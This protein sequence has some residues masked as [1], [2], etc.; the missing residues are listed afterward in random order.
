VTRVW[1]DVFLIALAFAFMAAVSGFG[2]SLAQAQPAAPAKRPTV[3]S[4]SLIHVSYSNAAW[5]KDPLK[6]E[7]ASILMREGTSGKIVQI[8][9]VETAPNSGV[10]SG[11]YSINWQ[12]L[13][14]LNVEF[15]VPPQEFFGENGGLKKLTSMIANKEIKRSPFVLKKGAGGGQTIQIY[16]SKEQA[17]LAVKAFRDSQLHGLMNKKFPSDQAVDVANMAADAKERAAA[18]K[19]AAERKRLGQTESQRIEELIKAFNALPAAEQAR[20][21]Q[22]AQEASERALA[23]YQKDQYP[24]ALVEFDKALDL[25]P[26]NR[27]YYFPFGVALYKT[28]KFNRSIVLLQLATDPSTRAV[29]RDFYIALNFFRQ[30]DTANALTNFDKVIAT[31]DPA[32]APASVFYEGMIKF[33]QKNWDEA[34][35][36]F[37]KVL[38]SS[39]DQTLDKKAEAYIEQ[40]LRVRQ[41]EAER[42]KKWQ[43]SATIGE[44]Y[45]S[46]V[47]LTSQ[48]AL[49][50]GVASNI[51]GFR[52]LFSGSVRYRP[53][54]EETKEF[55][56]QLD[57]M[58][59]Y[60]TD[61]SLN[62]SQTLRNADPAITT[63]TAPW[64]YK[65]ILF[66]KG[67]KFDVTPG[68]ETIF[69]SVEDNSFKPI[70]WS[71]L[72][73]FSNLFVMN[74]K[75]YTNFNLELR[76][77]VTGLGDSTATGDNN[78]SAIK[79]KFLYGNLIFLTD[80]KAKIL[81]TELSYTINQAQGIN[82]SYNRIDLAVG[83]V[84][85]IG[86]NVTANARLG[87]FNL[88]YPQNSNGR[89]DNSYMA[90]LGGSKKLNDVWS[91]GLLANYN[92][93]N[94]NVDVNQYSKWTA[95]ATLSALWGL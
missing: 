59:M 79:G 80:D 17:Q 82:E 5:N 60:T 55:A 75:L 71:G 53:I 8:N 90:T 65:G 9:L 94:S 81:T 25:D 48:S 39:Q 78:S 58:I 10:F 6:E 45:D 7:S 44:I 57:Q 64:T 61:T 29:E 21:K 77:D 42:A 14:K 92:V 12:N 89:I 70:V 1:M 31:E 41:F 2:E 93:N 76:D 28:E 74:E 69:M 86:W 56:V 84:Q 91:T 43:F 63:V 47:T 62:Y 85:P 11:V 37:Q 95:M 13:E 33:D 46:N 15:Y 27:A 18:A 83:Y 38:D 52:S 40:I 88:T 26:T 30:K 20:R 19:A 50:Q 73:N 54:Y 68:A 36:D 4:A 24:E 35:K 3:D 87:Y 67:Y 22:E 32:L 34:T 16:D 49:D 51:D 23:L 66:G 72:L